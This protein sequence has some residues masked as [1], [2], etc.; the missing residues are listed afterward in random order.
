MLRPWTIS[1]VTRRDLGR[2]KE[3]LAPLATW[4]AADGRIGIVL[5]NSSDL[6]ESPHVELQG[7]GKK[8]VRLHIDGQTKDHELELQTVIDLELAPRSLCLIEIK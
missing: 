1:R 7:S 6:G 4:R 8:Q 3:P 5:A 2:C